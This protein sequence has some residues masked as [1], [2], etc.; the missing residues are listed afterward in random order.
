MKK[1]YKNIISI[2]VAAAF[3]I[4]LIFAQ[5]YALLCIYAVSVTGLAIYISVSVRSAKRRGIYPQ[6]KVE[7]SDVK[8]LALS[9]H[10]TLAIRAYREIKGVN[11]K[12]AKNEVNKIIVTAR[13]DKRPGL[14]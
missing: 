12:T 11:L 14:F 2:A 7:I 9:G 4:W 13:N 8:R 5:Q 10:T 6:G 3:P 1:Q